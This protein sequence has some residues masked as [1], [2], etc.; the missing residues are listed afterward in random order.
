[1]ACFLTALL[2]LAAG[3]E[4]SASL[5]SSE[6]Q[7]PC[8]GLGEIREVAS[9]ALAQADA[10]RSN[11]NL[12]GAIQLL[13]SALVRCD[14]M[15]DSA[16]LYSRLGEMRA[17]HGDMQG[18]EAALR[19]ALDLNPVHARAMGT[20]ANVL[21]ASSGLTISTEKE[22]EALRLNIRARQLLA[23]E[24]GENSLRNAPLLTPKASWLDPAQSAALLDRVEEDG[25]AI[26]AARDALELGFLRE[27]QANKIFLTPREQSALDRLANRADVMV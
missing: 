11:A 26:I 25:P 7:G 6:L 14:G 27:K 2:T 20:L 19:R 3:E 18:A 21:A 9:A 22:F 15:D 12:Q 17:N 23:V 16:D 4:E 8:L 5:A 24:R 10:L 1:M 13:E